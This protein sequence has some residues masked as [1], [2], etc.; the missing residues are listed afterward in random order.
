M[1]ITTARAGKR[2]D[3]C[4]QPAAIAGIALVAAFASILVALALY[5]GLHFGWGM[6]GGWS[7]TWGRMWVALLLIAAVPLILLAV[8]LVLLA[9]RGPSA[10]PLVFSPSEVTGMEYAGVEVAY[11]QYR[12]DLKDITGSRWH[13]T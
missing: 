2:R 8:L 10:V 1:E 3:L 9:R 7:A 11:D 12:H 13:G 4:L 5:G 6:M